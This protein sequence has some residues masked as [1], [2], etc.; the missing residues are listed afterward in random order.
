MTSAEGST[1]H[2]EGTELAQLAPLE[3]PRVTIRENGET[4][5]R[6]GDVEAGK[7]AWHAAHESGVELPAGTKAI[8]G[9]LNLIGVRATPAD[10]IEVAERAGLPTGRLRLAAQQGLSPADQ[11]MFFRGFG[12]AT[13][14]KVLTRL[15]PIASGISDGQA[16]LANV[17][18]GTLWRDLIGAGESR[19]DLSDVY[20]DGSANHTVQVI[21]FAQDPDS[22]EIRGY[23]VND[24]ALA[25]GVARYVPQA[26]M[27]KAAIGT[28]ERFAGGS[29]IVTDL[30]R[31]AG[32]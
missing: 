15:H 4:V 18:A 2:H 22:R 13:Q 31:P 3:V 26:T 24:P 10:L 5:I 25:D 29:M 17:N 32:P 21:G 11:V 1:F 12:V 28:A 20:G 14:L 6:V 27:Q 9:V 7:L 19:Q 23:Y 30:R 8:A 16:V